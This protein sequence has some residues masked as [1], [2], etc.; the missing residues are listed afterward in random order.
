MSQNHHM[1]PWCNGYWMQEKYE[2]WD[3]LT[4]K[5]RHDITLVAILY[6]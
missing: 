1:N 5:N 3:K 4:E 2:S 6:I